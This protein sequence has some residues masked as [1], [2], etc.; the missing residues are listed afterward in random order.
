MTKT[1]QI[2]KKSHIFIIGKKYYYG[3]SVVK[4]NYE[5]SL[6]LFNKAVQLKDIESLF[7]IGEH[8]LNGLGTKKNYT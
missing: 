1:K 4:Q 6:S 2:N 7:F 8:Y 5:T 3:S